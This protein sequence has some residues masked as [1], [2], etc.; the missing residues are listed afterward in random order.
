MSGLDAVARGSRWLPGITRG[1]VILVL[2]C[3]ALVLAVVLPVYAMGRMMME[4]RPASEAQLAVSA[5]GD[6]LEV[7]LEGP[8][9]RRQ[10]VGG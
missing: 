8:L 2:V 1:R 4:T 7:A 6:Q 3:A 9:P 5:A 10:T